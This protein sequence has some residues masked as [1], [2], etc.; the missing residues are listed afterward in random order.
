MK[1]YLK[2]ISQLLY[3]MVILSIMLSAQRFIMYIINNESFNSFS[4]VDILT[5]IVKGLKYDI[6]T[7]FYINSIFI[8]LYLLPVKLYNSAVYQFI[9]KLVFVAG[10]ILLIIFNLIDINIYKNQQHRLL[11]F[12]VRQNLLEW[13][14]N[15]QQSDWLSFIQEY[16]SLITFFIGFLFIILL[17]SN[18]IKRRNY[19][20]KTDI[21]LLKISSF[22]TIF[23]ISATFTYFKIEQKSELHKNLYIEADRKLLPIL[24]NNPYLLISDY[25]ANEKELTLDD[26]W[27][28]SSYNAV[29]NCS[30]I[31]NLPIFNNIKIIVSSETSLPIKT[32]NGVKL[33]VINNQYD[34]VFQMLDEL[35]FSFPAIFRNGFYSSSYSFKKVESLVDILKTQGYF[36][37][38]KTFGYSKDS[39]DLIRNFYRFNNY[40]NQDSSKSFELIL[41][42][43]NTAKNNADKLANN[44]PADGNSIIINVL[45]KLKKQVANSVDIAQSIIFNSN[46]GLPFYTN[47]NF[48]ITQFLD[49]KPSILQL[50]GY[51]K[52][53]VSYGNSL[54]QRGNRCQY[55]VLSDSS[56]CATDKNLLLYYSNNQTISLHKLDSFTACNHN[57]ADSLAVER[58]LIEN[59]LQSMLYDFRKRMKKTKSF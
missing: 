54:F 11:I 22:I 53:F 44:L 55:H 41:V 34:N 56:Y 52:S 18:I 45:V 47:H 25:F 33:H 26:S 39:T 3:L 23:V 8:F 37:R 32:Q 5:V 4:I 24:V 59:K 58:T 28:L 17:L 29:N 36:I 20:S 43:K 21:I 13:W 48:L 57:L 10:N 27:Y 49:I 6:A 15:F 51:S 30:E 9:L 2:Q 16:L 50:I 14:T 12:D 31:N 46:V 7:V 38:L 35:L 1:T 19:E 40:A 42:N